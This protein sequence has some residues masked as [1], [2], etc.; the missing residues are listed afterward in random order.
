LGRIL[1][2]GAAILVVGWHVTLPARADETIRIGVLGPLTGP[3]KF[4]GQGLVEGATSAAAKIN[5]SRGVLDR[6]IE[7]ISLDDQGSS[8]VAAAK[9]DEA[10]QSLKLQF[11]VG[12]STRNTSLPAARIYAERKVL[13]I[14]PRGTRLPSDGPASDT[15]FS[16]CGG[17]GSYGEA[18][19]NYLAAPLK[20][21]RVGVVAEDDAGGLAEMLK[22]LGI[23]VVGSE[24]LDA[25]NMQAGFNQ[26]ESRGAQATLVRLT[27]DLSIRWSYSSKLGDMGRVSSKFPIIV[28]VAP[29]VPT[30]YASG[31]PSVPQV[32]LLQEIDQ[33][34]GLTNPPP[35]V[36]ALRTGSTYASNSFLFGYAAVQVIAAGIK[37]SRSFEPA[38]VAAWLR[39]G[40]ASPTILGP[41]KFDKSGEGS[42]RQFAIYGFGRGTLR[43][44]GT[45]VKCE[46]GC[47]CS[48]GGCGCEC[49]K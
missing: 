18:L 3:L 26:V 30:G 17:E 14:E 24:R 9:A 47:P 43:P 20:A 25:R 34:V 31:L 6:K 2:L 19:K 41:T 32:F 11:V 5:D 10:T 38:R 29:N 33:S 36:A 45:D 1:S 40:Q 16:L 49:K 39:S 8:Q 35:E 13:Q 44:D 48:E 22:K 4:Y 7:I 27:N 37:E 46:K 12:H 28:D 15:R 42:I 21:S 23:D